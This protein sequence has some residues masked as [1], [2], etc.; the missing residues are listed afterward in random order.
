MSF[1]SSQYQYFLFDKEVFELNGNRDFTIDL[2]YVNE[3]NLQK[4]FHFFNKTEDPKIHIVCKIKI[5]EFN[6]FIDNILECHSK[7]SNLNILKKITEPSFG[8][9]S[10]IAD[11]TYYKNC[12]TVNNNDSTEYIFKFNNDVINNIK[13]WS[14]RQK[15]KD[16][17]LSIGLQ[18]VL[19][20]G[21]FNINKDYQDLL[22]I[23]Y[24]LILPFFKAKIK[25]NDAVLTPSNQGEI[26]YDISF[27]FLH[28]N[29]FNE[30][31]KFKPSV[32]SQCIP[33]YSIVPLNLLLKGVPGTGK[34]LLVDNLIKKIG[35]DN[36]DQILRINIHTGTNNSDL[37]QGI[38]IQ[39]SSQN[40]IVYKEKQG[41]VLSHLMDAICNYPK[42]YVLI[43]EEIQ[44]NSLNRII[45]DLIYLIEPTKRTKIPIG[46]QGQINYKNIFNIIEALI[47]SNIATNYVKIPSLVELE[48]NRNL[49]IPDNFYVFCTSNYRD[50]KKVIEDNLLRR[51]DVV[52]LYPDSSIIKNEETKFF[53]E[54]LNDSIE[55]IMKDLD[56][57]PDRYSIGHANWL[58]GD[59]DSVIKPF[60]KT[61]IE[62]KDV[63]NLDFSTTN[64]ILFRLNEKLKNSS[65]LNQ[66][67]DLDSFFLGSVKSILEYDSYKSLII[68]L[69][70]EI[71][72]NLI[73]ENE[74]H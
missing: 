10:I 34:S 7:L 39:T 46:Y 17:K 69:Q 27:E 51:F 40:N 38:G 58:R 24:S 26:I 48:V 9:H 74:E 29:F 21:Y 43:L 61:I 36:K 72:K 65:Q 23:F 73:D 64:K 41:V 16:N 12:L 70:S 50:D 32:I 35:V 57:H 67:R 44:E 28:E 71:Y 62:F 1:N 52:E 59:N 60:L 13:Y 53:F 31:S 25:F 20:K 14:F 6:K 3:P 15:S 2:D 5:Q 4:V 37:M 11:P 63:K 42:P 49:I 8:N 68:Y 33:L 22:G 19:A 55:D 18:N 47:K 45:G 56:I 54:C 30:I 66:S